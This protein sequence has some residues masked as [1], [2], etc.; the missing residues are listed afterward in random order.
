[1]WSRVR[2]LSPLRA[3]WVTL[4]PDHTLQVGARVARRAGIIQRDRVVCP[5]QTLL[6]T[7]TRLSLGHLMACRHP[8]TDG[9][10]QRMGEGPFRGNLPAM[11]T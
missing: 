3:G 1:M 8:E 6:R 11:E 2:T 7:I 5:A 9:R 10:L 4:V